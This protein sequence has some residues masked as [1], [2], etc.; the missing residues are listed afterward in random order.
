MKMNDLEIPNVMNP[1][2]DRC[3]CGTKTCG[4]IRHI[5]D[6]GAE[7]DELRRELRACERH[8]AEDTRKLWFKIGGVMVALAAVLPTGWAAFLGLI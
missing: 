6:L 3:T 2:G 7:V 5:E 8:H 1:A 4:A